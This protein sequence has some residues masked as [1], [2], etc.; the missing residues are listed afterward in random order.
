MRIKRIAVWIVVSAFLIT[1]AGLGLE[2]V[3]AQDAQPLTA[4]V[5]TGS[6]ATLLAKGAGVQLPVVYTCVAAP[7]ITMSS[8]YVEV[9]L[10]QV[11]KKVV[12]RSYGSASFSPVC[13]GTQHT[14][15]LVVY[16]SY[17]NIAFRKGVALA[18]A[19]LNIF[20]RDPSGGEYGGYVSA[21]ASSAAEVKIQ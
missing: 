20:G 21:S 1:V 6:S 10:D 3:W 7:G 2:G 18:T 11:V 9:R 17:T 5:G 14:V 8:G 15:D 4:S 19:N 12:Y 13:D 16:S